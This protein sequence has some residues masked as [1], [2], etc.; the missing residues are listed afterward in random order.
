MQAISG[1]WPNFIREIQSQVLGDDGFG[2][3][4]DWGRARGR[5]FHGLASIVYLIERLPAVRIPP[6]SATMDKWLTRTTPVPQKFRTGILDTFRVYL[7]LVREKE[8]RK[9]FARRVSPIEFVM[10]GVMIYVKREILSLTQL[11]HAVEKLRADVRLTEKD[12]RANGRTTKLLFK[13]IMEKLPKLT[14]RSDGQGDKSAQSVL[15]TLSHELASTSPSSP[16]VESVPQTAASVGRPKKRRRQVEDDDND[17][18]SE[19]G[20]ADEEYVPSRHY[21][22]RGPIKASLQPSPSPNESPAPPPVSVSTS[23][24]IPVN[25]STTSTTPTPSL[26]EPGS[27]PPRTS[28]SAPSASTTASVPPTPVVSTY[29]LPFVG[30][31]QPGDSPH[32]PSHVVQ[33]DKHLLGSAG[34]P[35]DL[36]ALDKLQQILTLSAG[37]NTAQ[38]QQ[39]QQQQIQQTLQQQYQ[40]QSQLAQLAS[41]RQFQLPQQQQLQPEQQDQS[42][43]GRVMALQQL[44]ALLAVQ[45]PQ[46]LQQLQQLA[47]QQQAQVLPMTVPFT[48]PQQQLSPRPTIKAEY[49]EPSLASPPRRWPPPQAPHGLEYRSRRSRSR[50]RERERERGYDRHRDNDRGGEW[51]EHSRRGP[52]SYP[53]SRSRSRSRSESRSRRGRSPPHSRPADLRSRIRS[54]SR[55]P[56]RRYHNAGHHNAGHPNYRVWDHNQQTRGIPTGPGSGP[57]PVLSGDSTPNHS[58]RRP[59]SPSSM[60]ISASAPAGI[61]RKFEFTRR[62]REF[63]DF[64]GEQRPLVPD[65]Q[66]QGVR[67]R[68]RGRGRARGRARGVGFRGIGVVP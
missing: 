26:T 10:I 8:H 20:E 56:D 43:L 30:I 51:R 32:S 65:I 29:P 22:R 23:P 66:M 62:E 59:S 17:N 55:S 3:S 25:A 27:A 24:Q 35:I 50:S 64:G 67:G 15:Q 63:E 58:S 44:Q 5:D 7:A 4:F 33:S 68:G 52:A 49:V 46:Q 36:E 6:T 48:V 28:T 1:P 47:Q 11:S 21:A 37:I 14:L 2:H 19:L 61:A 53:R 57:G 12:V 13:F 60:L 40:T 54:R 31:R 41:M 38:Q 39:Q 42:N 9:P 34:A 18:D 45:P 16:H